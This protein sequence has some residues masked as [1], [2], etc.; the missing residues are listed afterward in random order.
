MLFCG[1][2]S[3]AF[4][5]TK[6]ELCIGRRFPF[7]GLEPCGSPNPVQIVHECCLNAKQQ[8]A[9]LVSSKMF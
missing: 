7:C 2:L 8:H 9:L 5:L 3:L 6:Y 4:I 1:K